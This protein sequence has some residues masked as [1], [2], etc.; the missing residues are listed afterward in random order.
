MFLTGYAAEIHAIL[1]EGEDEDL[2]DIPINL[3]GINDVIA[4]CKKAGDDTVQKF[5]DVNNLMQECMS[6]SQGK[7]QRTEAIKAEVDR[8]IAA[9]KVEKSKRGQLIREMEEKIDKLEEQEEEERRKYNDALDS[10]NG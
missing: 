4:E 1:T 7:K 6:K 8:L 5:R 10:M 2:Q 3:E 9:G